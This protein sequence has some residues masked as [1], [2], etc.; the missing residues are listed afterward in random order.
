MT[1]VIYPQDNGE[2]ITVNLGNPIWA[3]V[4]AWLL[5]GAGHFYQRRFPKGFL[6]L[7]VILSTYFA[8]LALGEG[9]VVYASLKKNDIRWQYFFQAGVGLPAAPAVVQALKVKNE[10]DA[11]FFIMCERYPYEY[12]SLIHI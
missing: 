9:R 7:I 6:F 4:F 10:N 12:L 3:A 8:G 2:D 5:P 1:K 11:P